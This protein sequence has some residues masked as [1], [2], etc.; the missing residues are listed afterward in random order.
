M[1][2]LECNA[3]RTKLSATMSSCSKVKSII[4]EQWITSA[5]VPRLIHPELTEVTL[6]CVTFSNKEALA[7]FM[8]YLLSHRRLMKLSVEHDIISP[9]LKIY[10]CLYT[11]K[12]LSLKVACFDLTGYT[13]LSV[14]LLAAALKYHRTLVDLTVRV[15]TSLVHDIPEEQPLRIIQEAKN[16]EFLEM[17][18]NRKLL[19][20]YFLTVSRLLR[21]SKQLIDLYCGMPD[22][23]VGR[24]TAKKKCYLELLSDVKAY[25]L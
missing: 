22:L 24:K 25:K 23:V 21:N 16:L 13:T 14:R 17:S 7:K 9:R 4:D 5:Q 8:K 6:C 1:L 3:A 12:G 20:V 11:N 18:W 2:V 19:P 15:N 10:K